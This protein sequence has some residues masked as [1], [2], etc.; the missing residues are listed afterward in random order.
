MAGA[1]ERFELRHPQGTTP[2]FYG[3][4]ALAAATAEL[5]P[6]IADRRILAVSSAP[7]VALHDPLLDPLRAVA[8]AFD[9]VEVPDGEAAKTPAEAERLWRAWSAFGGRRDALVVAFGG[10]SVG[11]LAGF[12]AGAFLR[13][14]DWLALPTT[15]LAQ[16]DAAVGGKTA[17]DLPEAKNSVGLFHHPRA[18]VADRSVLATL[19]LGLRRA[20]LVEALKTGAMLDLGLF[21]R[22]ERDLDRAL[23]GDLEAL[24][25][26]AA[27]A[28]RAK[29]R[30][31]ESDPEEAGARKL[32]NFGHTLGHAIEA[33]AG[34]GRVAHGDAVAHGMRFALALSV[35]LGGDAD[36]AARVGA[37]LD[38]L[39]PPPLPALEAARLLER[40]GRDKK[41]R[42]GGLGWV[43]LDG[44]GRGA[45]DRQVPS[46]RIV[47]EIDRFLRAAGERPL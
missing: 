38:R 25:A 8:S 35:A 22:I 16:V 19:P 45:W 1:I 10:G 17:V 23:G 11:D 26:V 32:L 2:H 6:M 5:A 12:A 27:G 31:V 34:Y 33:E 46:E 24:A 14:V 7:I 15:L 18:V 29:A 28:A 4:G 41:A 3:D 13:G 9:L 43:L 44:P 30:L 42:R 39:A 21:E 47:A 37:A 20:G 36:F 40:T